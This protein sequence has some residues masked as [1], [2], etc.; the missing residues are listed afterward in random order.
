MLKE[1]VDG[2]RIYFEFHLDEQL[3]YKEEKQYTLDY[4]TE[5]NMSKCSKK[6]N[7]AYDAMNF[8]MEL[9]PADGNLNSSNG[10][11]AILGG[12]EYEKQ[13]EQCLLYI[14]K[15]SG[16]NNT[17]HAYDQRTSPYIAAYKLPV[18]MRGFLCETFS[19]RLLSAES[20]P[21]RSM[22]FGAPHLAR[23]LGKV[24]T[25]LHQ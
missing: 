25:L 24:I 2:L 22:V 15:N 9:I 11:D 7:D 16:K 18:E 10:T 12:I 19:W 23:L 4:L 13:L 1:V 20:A 14:V 6:L 17:A 5:E 3:L 21:E 8:E